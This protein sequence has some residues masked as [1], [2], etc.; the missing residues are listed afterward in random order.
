MIHDFGVE[1]KMNHFH[2]LDHERIH[3]HITLR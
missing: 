3:V 2:K 1:N